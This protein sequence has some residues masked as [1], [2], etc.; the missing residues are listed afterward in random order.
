MAGLK[1]AQALRGDGFDGE[2]VLIDQEDEPTYDKPPLSK[3]YLA[4]ASARDEIELLTQDEF[5]AIRATLLFGQPAASL[6]VEGSRV[7]LA[8]GRIVPY[9][10][11]VIAAGSRA[12]RSPWGEGEHI[13]V[14]RTRG[15]AERLRDELATAK[16]IVVI[17]AGFIGAEAASTARKSGVQVSM[18]DP[19]P[20]PMS[21]VLNSQVGAIFAR[22]YEQEGVKEY[23]GRAVEGIEHTTLGVRVE[24]DGGEFIHADAALV[25]IGAVVNTEWLE[26]SGLELENGV[27]CDSAL[28]VVGHPN[29]YAVGDIA[30][31]RSAQRGSS[32]RLEHWTNAVDQ[33]RI[34]S[35]NIM[36]PGDPS[37]YETTEYVWSDQYDWKIQVVG[38]TGS[39]DVVM[40][41]SEADQR[42]AALYSDDGVT[43]TGALIVNWPRA[44]IETRRGVASG[45]SR[46]DLV[47]RLSTQQAR[48]SPAAG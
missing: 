2:I 26:N 3:G 39:E 15:D 29:I 38:R 45:G 1:T 19:F 11:L 33:A 13:H 46:S 14:L 27:V 37:D 28:R 22:K 41:G 17:G 24:L 20:A 43:L 4:G 23:F 7:I 47:E 10:I 44:L 9:D 48:R 31:W 35:R 36:N 5:R 40:L 34:V 21:R 16:H 42:V 6:D 12:R 32:L 8:D 30:R 25:G 18:V